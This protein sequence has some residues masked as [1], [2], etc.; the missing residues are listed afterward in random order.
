MTGLATFL[1]SSAVAISLIHWLRLTNARLRAE[2]ARAEQ[3][4]SR[5]AADLHAM[6]QLVQLSHR[7]VRERTKIDDCLNEVIETAISVSGADKGTLQLLN[8]E[9]RHAHHSG[10][11]RFRNPLSEVLCKCA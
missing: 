8:S 1:L 9:L 6:T 3:A 2:R 7:L 4:E 11:A 10:P 5:I